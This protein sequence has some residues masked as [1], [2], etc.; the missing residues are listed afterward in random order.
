MMKRQRQA[1]TQS[2]GVPVAGNTRVPRLSTIFSSSGLSLDQPQLEVP[3]SSGVPPNST[4]TSR[5]ATRRTAGR[6][7]T[8]SRVISGSFSGRYSRA[9]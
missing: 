7:I 3:S 6:T 5:P 2:V 4:N 8:G 1:S 9:C